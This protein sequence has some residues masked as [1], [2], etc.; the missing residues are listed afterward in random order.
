MDHADATCSNPKEYHVKDT[1]MGPLYASRMTTVA[2]KFS[3]G[4]T[5]CHSDTL[6][7]STQTVT[8]QWRNRPYERT[9]GN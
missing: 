2:S 9:G 7:G 1:D 4:S 8:C 3:P 6:P 5:F